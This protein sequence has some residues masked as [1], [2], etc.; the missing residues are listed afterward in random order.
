MRIYSEGN[1]VRVFISNGKNVLVRKALHKA[2]EELK[3]FHANRHESVNLSQVAHVKVFDAKRFEFEMS[4][5]TRIVLS[6]SASLNLKG[7]SL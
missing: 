6:R 2:T 4:D 7:M 3:L 5:G 1:Y